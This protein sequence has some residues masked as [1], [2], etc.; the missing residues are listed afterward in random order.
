LTAAEIKKEYEDYRKKRLALYKKQEQLKIL[1]DRLL[2]VQSPHLSGMPHATATI[3]KVEAAA[4][5]V[6]MCEDEIKQMQQTDKIKRVGL[7]QRLDL[8]ED[9]LKN[10]IY[11]Y[12]LNAYSESDTIEITF[13]TISGQQPHWKRSIRRRYFEFKAQAFEILARCKSEIRG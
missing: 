9:D 7:L 8:L 5:A 10:I 1:K 3:S 12:Y 11:F 6:L 4:E 2:A 13:T